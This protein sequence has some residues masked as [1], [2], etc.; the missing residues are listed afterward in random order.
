MEEIKQT[1]QVI[2]PG[3]STD[4]QAQTFVNS[5][6]A[7]NSTSSHADNLYFVLSIWAPPQERPQIAKQITQVFTKQYF[8]NS[9]R[10]S[11]QVRFS[12]SLKVVNSGIQELNEY[13]HKLDQRFHVE[14]LIMTIEGASFLLTF[15]G[16]SRVFR[17]HGTTHSSLADTKH[18]P[19]KLNV[20]ESVLTGK[21]KP[22]DTLI[23][24]SA[25]FS[26]RLPHSILLEYLE[27]TEANAYDKFETKIKTLHN[28]QLGIISI[29]ISSATPRPTKEPIK[30]E[31]THSKPSL[32]TQALHLFGQFFSRVAKGVKKYFGMLFQGKVFISIKKKLKRAWNNLFSKYINPNPMIALSAVMLTIL[33]FTSIFG[34]FIWYNPHNQTLK[35]SYV[36]LEQNIQKAQ[37]QISNN[38]KSE[39]LQ[40][41]EKTRKSIE[42]IPQKDQQSLN[43]LQTQAK[44]PTLSELLVTITQLED[45]IQGITR[46][47][48]QTVYT[49]P[50]SGANYSVVAL[51]GDQLYAIN[52]TTGDVTSSAKN[53]SSAKTIGTSPL[54]KGT[55]SLAASANTS[56]LFALTPEAVFQIKLDGSITKQ[57]SPSGWPSSVSISS[58]VQNIYLLSP[59]DN[60][61]YR[62][63]KTPSG[64]GTRNAYIKKPTPG[65]LSDSTSTSVNGTVFVA[66][67]TGE[68]LLF[69]QGIQKQ[70]QVSN[71]PADMQDI[72]QLIYTETPDQ[73]IVLNP[74]KKA[75]IIINLKETGGEYSKEIIVNNTSEITSFTYSSS[76]KNVYFTSENSLYKLTI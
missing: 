6:A 56:S 29:T 46:I 34:Y 57:T 25:R 73:L 8:T 28:H 75:F 24:A 51:L 10:L 55:V 15:S 22:E 40:T 64:F 33:I 16:D 26:D 23:L 12:N 49:N 58:Y 1:F 2:K 69:D 76:D 54:L 74:L 20:F 44:K 43:T 50:Q 27:S 42:T 3:N 45:K 5:F 60:Q 18:K 65:L 59:T 70:F 14:A 47:S 9:D 36:L 38:Q 71:K 53:A 19:M 66:K 13:Y 63:S 72:S 67:R 61:I 21:A 35:Q 68:V 30:D 4:E 48:A 62:Y 52:Q 11:R 7:Q 32:L 37:S 17:K 41:L 39:A 31:V